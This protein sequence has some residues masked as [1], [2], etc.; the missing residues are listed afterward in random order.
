MSR[1][2]HG[3]PSLGASRHRRGPSAEHRVIVPPAALLVVPWT[4]DGNRGR[5]AASRGRADMGAPGQGE[6]LRVLLHGS[7]KFGV[8]ADSRAE[9]CGCVNSSSRAQR[10]TFSKVIRNQWRRSLAALGMTLASRRLAALATVG[11]PRAGAPGS[12]T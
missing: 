10:G 9:E 5:A 3:L 11:Y 4:L 6:T 7:R 1:P 2:V 8:E 12:A